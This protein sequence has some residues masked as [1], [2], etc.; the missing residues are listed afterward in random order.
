ML[1]LPVFWSFPEL[2]Y[3]HSPSRYTRRPPLLSGE[4]LVSS[5]LLEVFVFQSALFVQLENST[6]LLE[7]P[8]LLRPRNM[9]ETDFLDFEL[10]RVT[11][12]KPAKAIRLIWNVRVYSVPRPLELFVSL[13]LRVSEWLTDFKYNQMM[14]RCHVVVISTCAEK[15]LAWAFQ[16]LKTWWT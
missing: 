13:G 15:T 12:K 3:E 10:S 8:H 6:R 16:S 1:R 9:Q 11:R 2:T 5:F 7:S 14:A 4:L